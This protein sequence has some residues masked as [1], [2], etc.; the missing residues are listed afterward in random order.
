MNYMIYIDFNHNITIL[1]NTLETFQDLPEFGFRTAP[2][3]SFRQGMLELSYRFPTCMR[4]SLT[5]KI[6]TLHITR[7]IRYNDF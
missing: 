1:L 7:I 6:A 3:L 2:A 4:I 5:I